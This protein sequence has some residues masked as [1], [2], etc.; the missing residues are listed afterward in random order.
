MTASMTGSDKPSA[1][2][3]TTMRLDLVNKPFFSASLI[4]PAL[5]TSPSRKFNCAEFRV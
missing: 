2:E 5:M 1:N 4:R 3:A